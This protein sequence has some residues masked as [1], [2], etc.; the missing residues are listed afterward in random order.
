MTTDAQ[1]PLIVVFTR[2]PVLGRVKTRLARA[3]GERA[4]FD[5]H[6]TL[7]ERT[8]DAVTGSGMDAEIWVDGDPAAL[9]AHRLPVRHQRSGS[10]DLGE[11]MLDAIV[12]VTSRQRT[13]ILI[14]SDCPLL[15]APYLCAA[16]KFLADGADLVVGPVEDGGYVLIGMPKPHPELF[17][18][19]TW[20]T[21]G[22]CAE[23]L[24][25]AKDA[26]LTTALLDQLWDVDDEADWRRWLNL[27][28]AM[29]P[30]T[31]DPRSSKS[32]E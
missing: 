10:A 14:G 15:D 20:S 24:R 13:A 25:R 5:L 27:T 28:G 32:S 23:T 16:A 30:T 9:P 6:R 17:V 4:A 2:A 19:M 21:P 3:V 12:D 8:L 1:L 31:T 29:P 18:S 11:R 22:V 7:L 26:R